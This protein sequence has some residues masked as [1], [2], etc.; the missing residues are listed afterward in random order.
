MLFR[1]LLALAV[2]MMSTLSV[3]CCKDGNDI[4]STVAPVETS[5]GGAPQTTVNYATN[6]DISVDELAHAGENHPGYQSVTDMVYTHCFPIVA[7][8]SDYYRE[9]TLIKPSFETI[10]HTTLKTR[11]SETDARPPI[12]DVI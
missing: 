3:A 7:S 5:M 11:A 2:V 4:F 8:V 6:L 9:I 1:T 10:I 12:K